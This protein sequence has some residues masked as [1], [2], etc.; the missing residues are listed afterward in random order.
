MK[1]G[2][3][4]I[5][6]NVLISI[7]PSNEYHRQLN[8]DHTL[9]S[10]CGYLGRHNHAKGDTHSI[11]VPQEWLYMLV[12]TASSHVV[13]RFVPMCKNQKGQSWQMCTR[14]FMHSSITCPTQIS[15]VKLS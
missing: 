10:F 7:L 14:V 13:S 3:L 9:S 15:I 1:Q 12:S 6:E 11:D 4:Y 5:E 8:L 2:L